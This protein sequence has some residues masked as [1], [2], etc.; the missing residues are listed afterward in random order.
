MS[1]TAGYSLDI[2]QYDAQEDQEAFFGK[3]GIWQGPLF[4]LFGIWTGGA[5]RGW[6]YRPYALGVIREHMGKATPAIFGIIAV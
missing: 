3:F 2:L 4:G 6:R 1:E 5:V